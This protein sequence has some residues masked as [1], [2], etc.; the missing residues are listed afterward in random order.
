MRGYHR[1][2]DLTVIVQ[3]LNSSLNK[4]DRC[5]SSLSRYLCFWALNELKK[6]KNIHETIASTKVIAL[7][8]ES[9]MFF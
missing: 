8:L 3:T 5:E 9:K 6:D 4:K 2:N 7:L 1:T